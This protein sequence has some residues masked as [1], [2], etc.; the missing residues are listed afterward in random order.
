M[1]SKAAQARVSAIE[2]VKL[3][4]ARI[5][6]ERLAADKAANAAA[7]AAQAPA[8]RPAAPATPVAPAEQK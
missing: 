6:R 2:Q 3:D 5:T 8:P 1:A 7:A 4:A